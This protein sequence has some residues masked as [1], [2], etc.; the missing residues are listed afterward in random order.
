MPQELVKSENLPTNEALPGA[1]LGWRQWLAKHF[2]HVASKP[3][4]KRHENLWGWA[5]TL[6]PGVRP[7]ARVEV[8]PRGGAKSSTGELATTWVG[9]KLTRR[10]VLIVSE[11]QDQ[12]NKHVQSISSLFEQMGADRAVG[13]YGTSKG[14][15]RDQLR[16]SN[17]FNVAGLGLDV[18]ARGIK[19]DEFRPDLIIFDDI[20][21]QD[22]TPKTVKKKVAD[23]TTKILPAGSTDCA[24]LFLQ[25]LIH[26]GGIV[27]SLTDDTAEFLYDRETACIEPAVY[28][29][30]TEI[31]QNAEGKNVYQIVAGT[32]S[33]EGQDLATAQYQINLWGWPAFDK[34]AQQNVKG[35]NG[36]IFNVAQ[37]R[38]C[39]PSEVPPIEAICNAWDLAATEGAGDWTAGPL[40]GKARNGV[41]YIFGVIRGQWSPERVQACIKYATKDYRAAWPELKVKLPQDPGQAGKAQASHLRTTL[42]DP[43]QDKQ[44]L[45]IATVQGNKIKRA[46]PFAECV[47]MGN[48]VLVEQDLP[49][50]LAS[51]L[52]EFGGRVLKSD[53]SWQ[54]WHKELRKELKDIRDVTTA[55]VDD[56]MDG[57]A[58]SYNDLFPTIVP[59]VYKVKVF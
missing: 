3:F 43:E 40:M 54:T 49:A 58:D 41:V 52:A 9:V 47:N 21:N 56:Q 13:K 46:K 57:C 45:S 24:V 42:K 53:L 39:K 11:T 14:W 8:W 4:A 12:A 10:F 48:C 23:I 18:A 55:Q 38:T 28:G 29:L 35:A 33:W 31:V 26:E 17:G 6:T 36:Y 22:D 50:W 5:D 32:P 51:P 25:N 7:R 27:Y 1:E 59:T 16:V 30:K 44:N 15:R 20:D 2:P 19:L 34:E 37:F